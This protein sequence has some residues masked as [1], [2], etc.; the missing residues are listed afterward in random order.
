ML[1]LTSLSN[2]HLPSVGSVW[3]LEVGYFFFHVLCFRYVA[4]ALARCLYCDCCEV[5]QLNSTAIVDFTRPYNFSSGTMVL[6]VG[7]NRRRKEEVEG[8]K[9]GENRERKERERAIEF[10]CK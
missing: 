8:D 3:L 4:L 2:R 9:N 5:L 6:C 10:M 1:F 7:E